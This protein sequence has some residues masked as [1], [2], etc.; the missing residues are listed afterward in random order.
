LETSQQNLKENN[1]KIVDLEQHIKE[2]K[3]RHEEKV[4]KMEA[5]LAQQNKLIIFLQ[6]KNES[7]KKKR[8]RLLDIILKLSFNFY[9][10]RPLLIR[11]LEST[12]KKI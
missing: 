12:P 8:V 7:C 1:G 4:V 6:S 9:P 10:F 2:L 5:Q 11:S 3:A